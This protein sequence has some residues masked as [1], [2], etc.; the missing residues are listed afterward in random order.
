MIGSQIKYWVFGIAGVAGIYLVLIAGSGSQ[1]FAIGATLIAACVGAMA[2][3]G[4][5]DSTKY[6][7]KVGPIPL[8][9]FPVY[10]ELP[11]LMIHP[12]QV[13]RARVEVEGAPAAR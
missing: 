12:S 2:L 7:E 6:A 11:K 4:V 10:F 9:T 5:W 3:G 13:L 1:P 8:G